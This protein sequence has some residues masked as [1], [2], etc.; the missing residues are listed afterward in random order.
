M[1]DLVDLIATD[2]SAS[3]ISD[4]IKERLYARSAE[5]IDAARQTVGADLFGNEV[6]NEETPEAESELEV[7]DEPDS[8]EETE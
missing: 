5:Y 2:A 3:D 7:E 4:K 1:E 6:P 8:N